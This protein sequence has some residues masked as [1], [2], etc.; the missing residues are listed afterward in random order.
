[1]KTA[2]DVTI[3]V[4]EHQR[5]EIGERVGESHFTAE[6]W[7]A[8]RDFQSQQARPF[9]KVL[10]GGIAFS[11][12]VGA[13]QTKYGLVEI[14]PKTDRAEKAT[15]Q[16]FLLELL[17]SCRCFPVF[18]PDMG[19]IR[20]GV[21]P[22]VSA[23]LLSFINEVELW[24]KKGPSPQYEMQIQSSR[25]WKGSV[26]WGEQIKRQ[27]THADEIITQTQVFTSDHRLNRVIKL[28]LQ[29][30]CNVLPASKDRVKALGLLDRLAHWGDIHSRRIDWDQIMRC[31]MDPS[32]QTIISMSKAIITGYSGGIG[33]GKSP[34]LALLFDMNVLF[35]TYVYQQLAQIQLPGL[36]VSRQ[37]GRSFWLDRV[38][39]PD[40]VMQ[41]QEKKWV[42]DTKW[43]LLT[44]AQPSMDDLRQLFVYMQYFHATRGALIYPDV[45]GVNDIPPTPF[46]D[47]GDGSQE[48]Q[49]Q[50]CFVS[51][52][53]NG[54]L[55]CEFG[56][57]LLEKIAR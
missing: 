4:F 29:L 53:K 43:K 55:N 24:I 54:R 39:I 12:Y 11:S 37:P 19:L 33:A 34:V 22:L 1:M 10:P 36:W 27:L 41:Y 7:Q 38:L 30:A 20:P 52:V 15:W 44:Q 8:L 5:V 56:K 31:P 3:R 47:R 13:I 46:A 2:N 17:T 14:W 25:A 9:F 48:R 51:L 49:V 32:F 21:F 57:D 42:L 35:E 50:V 26:Q 6:L 16:P 40:I 28:A 23:F 45:N 18:T